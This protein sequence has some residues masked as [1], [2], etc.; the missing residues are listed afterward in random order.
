MLLNCN[1]APVS[2]KDDLSSFIFSTVV[3]GA[4]SNTQSGSENKISAA[5]K[6]VV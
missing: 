3:Q 1:E 5:K 6:Q 2:G 4:I